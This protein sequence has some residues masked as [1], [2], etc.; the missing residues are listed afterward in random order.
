M[1]LCFTATGTCSCVSLLG[2]ALGGG[3][4]LQQGR[5]GLTADHLVNLNVVL[6]NGTTVSVNETS[7]PD[8]WWAIRGA[9]HNFGIVTSFDSK[10]RPENFRQ[11]FVRT[12]QFGGSSLN[13]LIERVNRFQGNGTLD[14]TWLGAFGLYYMNQSLSQNEVSNSSCHL[15]DEAAGSWV[16]NWE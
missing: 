11:Y 16:P 14:P 4:G 12:Y 7:H 6:A 15:G 8:L 2:P 10:I 3:H 9:G 5:H 13:A 1:E